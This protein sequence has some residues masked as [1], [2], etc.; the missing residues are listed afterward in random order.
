[1]ELFNQIAGVIGCAV[2]LFT[3]A[4]AYIVTPNEKQVAF[5][6]FTMNIFGF[7]L[8]IFGLLYVLAFS[9]KEGPVTHAEVLILLAWIFNIRM[10]F[11]IRPKFEFK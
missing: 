10:A 5:K 4:L 8:F 1:M 7:S 9:M 2:A 3:F 6:R 11:Y